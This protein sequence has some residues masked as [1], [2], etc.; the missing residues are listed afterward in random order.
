VTDC[1]V[2]WDGGYET[3]KGAKLGDPRVAALLDRLAKN[4]ALRPSVEFVDDFLDLA[5]SAFVTDPKSRYCL[6]CGYPRGEHR[7]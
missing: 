5:C 1:I 3:I 7:G 6:E 4:G 2:K